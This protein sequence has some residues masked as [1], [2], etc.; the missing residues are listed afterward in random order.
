MAVYDTR[1][2][3]AALDLPEA[4]V[5]SL[6]TRFAIAGVERGRQGFR[7]R[8][9]AEAV[10]CIAIAHSL[11]TDLGVTGEA[12][13]S[14]AHELVRSKGAPLSRGAGLLTITFD[15][16][17][18]RQRIRAALDAAVVRDTEVRRGRPRIRR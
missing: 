9:S 5:S 8:L 4:W 2:A 3:A 11:V 15:A 17:A 14:L 16:V 13:V 18:S 6:L 7:R 12:A 1:V 10:V